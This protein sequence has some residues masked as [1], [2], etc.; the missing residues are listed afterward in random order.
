MSLTVEHAVE[1]CVE[2]HA[3]AVG[4]CGL[5]G[6]FAADGRPVGAGPRA[7]GVLT[8]A[9]VKI[10]GDA[11]GLIRKVHAAGI[12]RVGDVAAARTDEQHVV[13]ALAYKIRRI[14]HD[15]FRG[16][17]SHTVAERGQTRELGGRVDLVFRFF[18]V[19]P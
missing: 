16:W 19:V 14:A 3:V 6:E 8:A 10:G 12:D 5:H 11:D 7:V 15:F 1:A 18:G 9:H 17:V 13:D 2:R 4:F